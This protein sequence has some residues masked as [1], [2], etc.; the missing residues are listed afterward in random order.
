[1]DTQASATLWLQGEYAPIGASI[2]EVLTSRIG[3]D[4]AIVNLS[5]NLDLVPANADLGGAELDLAKAT[6]GEM[7]LRKAVAKVQGRYDYIIIDTPPNLMLC[8]QNALTASEHVAIPIDSKPQAY[9]SVRPLLALI[10]ELEQ[11]YELTL[12]KLALPTIVERTNVSKSIAGGIQ[13]AFDVCAILPPIAKSVRLVEAYIERVPI[14]D[15]D[16]TGAAVA[17][18]RSAAEALR[19][20][21]A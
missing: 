19:N 5:E 16:P 2:Y 9:E 14:L 17:Q 15:Y 7:R 12:H 13:D 4:D 11:E 8:T 20:A 10:A 6:N 1:M 3:L 18:Y 21:V